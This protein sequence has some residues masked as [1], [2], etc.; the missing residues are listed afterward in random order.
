MEAYQHLGPTQTNIFQISESALS[1]AFQGH[2]W[3]SFSSPSLDW[4]GATKAQISVSSSDLSVFKFFYCFFN[5]FSWRPPMDLKPDMFLLFLQLC[6]SWGPLPSILLL[7]RQGCASLPTPA[8]CKSLEAPTTKTG[9]RGY[10]L[11]SWPVPRRLPGLRS[12]HW[13]LGFQTFLPPVSSPRGH[14]SS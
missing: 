2:G 14:W 9:P 11:P 5:T 10:T 4:V 12:L 7:H 1:Q 6:T 3:T 13:S 8:H